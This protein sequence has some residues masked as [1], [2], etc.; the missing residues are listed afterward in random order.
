VLRCRLPSQRPSPPTHTTSFP[1]PPLQ[2]GIFAVL[3]VLVA[4]WAVLFL[5]PTA[6]LAWKEQA[7]HRGRDDAYPRTSFRRN[8]RKRGSV[9]HLEFL[10]FEV[11]TRKEL[12]LGDS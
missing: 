6:L 12:V 4:S 7:R 5:V 1:P 11:E 10:G 8:L 9:G 2:A 3:A